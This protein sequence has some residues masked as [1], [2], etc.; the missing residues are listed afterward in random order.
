M[1]KNAGV[2]GVK[3]LTVCAMPYEIGS[4]NN[5]RRLQS[6]IVYVLAKSEALKRALKSANE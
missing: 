2:L 4:N 6:A 5:P 3:K 1:F